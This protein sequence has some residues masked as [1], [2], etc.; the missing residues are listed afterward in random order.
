MAANAS[1]PAVPGRFRAGF[2]PTNSRTA[3]LRAMTGRD[4]CGRA[5][6]K[7]DEPLGLVG[8]REQPF[9]ERDRDHAV[10]RAMQD[11]DRRRA[12][13]R[14]AGRSG[15]DP[16][17]EDGPAETNRPR[18]PTSAAEVNGDSRTRPP[19]LCVAASATATP[20]PSDSPHSTMR[21]AGYARGGEGIGRLARPRS[22]RSRS[23]CRSSRRSRDSSA[24][25]ARCRPRSTRGS[26]RRACAARRHCPGN[27]A[28]PAGRLR[29]H[30]PDDHLLAVGGVEHDLLGAAAGRPPPAACAAAPGNTSASAAP[31]TSARRSRRTPRARRAAI[32]AS[33]MKS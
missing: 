9:A 13:C 31:D 6:G 5:F 30:V 28:P 16:S 27:R 7:P 17:S 14:S 2:G 32:S 8:Q 20:L 10:A 26:G 19:I 3:S 4:R 21:S 22:A 24:R 15:M 33:V 29:R 1:A 18:A 25:R 11:Q 12:P 23:D